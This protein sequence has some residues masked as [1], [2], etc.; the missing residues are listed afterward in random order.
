MEMKEIQTKYGVIYGRDALVLSGTELKLYPFNFIIN[1][2]LS[3]SACKPEILNAPDVK[4]KF[5]F[6]DIERLS[7]YKLDEYPNEKH[8]KSSF[9]YVDETHE[10]ENKH[11]ILSTYDHVF[12]IIGKYEVEYN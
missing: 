6:S 8:S 12:D 4:V 11:I 5:I 1:T 3:L 9:D 7:I 10:D 2:S